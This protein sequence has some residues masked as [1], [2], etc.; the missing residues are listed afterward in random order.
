MALIFSATVTTVI[1]ADAASRAMTALSATELFSTKR[2]HLYLPQICSLALG[3]S[4][5]LNGLHA[6]AQE[7]R[8]RRKRV[9]LTTCF[10]SVN[11]HNQSVQE[12]TPLAHVR[13]DTSADAWCQSTAQMRPDQDAHAQAL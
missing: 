2:C 10:T 7:C 8:L 12:L 5:L 3:C 13:K 4:A 1:A 9:V 6:S 11:M